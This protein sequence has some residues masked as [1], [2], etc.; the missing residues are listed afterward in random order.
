MFNSWTSI[1]KSVKTNCKEINLIEFQFNF[2]NW[3]VV[4][5]KE[6]LRFGIT[7]DGKCLYCGDL[8]SIDHT[9]IHWPR[10]TTD[11]K[12][13]S[14]ATR[15]SNH[16]NVYAINKHLW[17]KF[18]F[19][20]LMFLF[21]RLSLMNSVLQIKPKPLEV[22]SVHHDARRLSIDIKMSFVS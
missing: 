11:K 20:G 17:W 12:E 1:F 16:V 3:T 9:F 15:S 14:K 18:I 4:T 6:L 10:L 8:D 7:A 22:S 13:R 19:L 2:L 21:D 5:R